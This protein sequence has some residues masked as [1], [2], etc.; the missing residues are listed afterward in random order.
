MVKKCSKTKLI[1]LSRKYISIPAKTEIEY[2]YYY[3]TSKLSFYKEMNSNLYLVEI[4]FT[5]FDKEYV[6][7]I[8]QTNCFDKNDSERKFIRLGPDFPCIL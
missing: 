7:N 6:L 8:E 2:C 1:K 4:E 3:N 5:F